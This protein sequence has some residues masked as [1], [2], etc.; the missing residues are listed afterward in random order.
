M[1]KAE[2]AKKTPPTVP[3]PMQMSRAMV[4]SIRECCAFYDAR[5]LP[6][7][8]RVS[9]VERSAGPLGGSPGWAVGRSRLAVQGWTEPRALL[10]GQHIGWSLEGF[11]CRLP[12]AA[13]PSDRGKELIQAGR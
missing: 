12:S 13:Q 9:G 10:Y 11:R 1:T 2:K 6:F 7:R 5:R 8:R 4:E 3:A